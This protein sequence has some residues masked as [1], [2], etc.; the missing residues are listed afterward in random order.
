MW[1]ASQKAAPLI[2][3][4]PLE[5]RAADHH[6]LDFGCPLFDQ[7]QG[8]LRYSRSISYSFE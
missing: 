7:G 6:S 5:Q 8:R 2:C 3:F 4:V 1:R